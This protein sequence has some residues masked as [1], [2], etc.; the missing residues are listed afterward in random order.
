MRRR[1]Q[2]SD[3]LS[4][5]LDEITELRETVAKQAATIRALAA[6]NTKLATDRTD[7]DI[8][9]RHLDA[10]LTLACRFFISKV[11]PGGQR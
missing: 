1:Q 11:V 5:C 2:I 9:C 6:V 4:A 7:L 10:Q 8:R 3:D